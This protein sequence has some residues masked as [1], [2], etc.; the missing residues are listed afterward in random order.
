MKFAAG[1]S[2]PCPGGTPSEKGL[3]IILS[4]RV[5]VTCDTDDGWQ[6]E[7]SLLPG[8]AFGGKE[9]FDG[10]TGMVYTAAEDTMVY[11]IS[12]HSFANLA[13]LKPDVLF[14]VL[15]AAYLPPGKA[16]VP[17]EEHADKDAPSAA[18]SSA[19][20]AS[21]ASGAVAGTAST[22]GSG[23]AAAGAA[24]TSGVAAPAAA[25]AAPVPDIRAQAQA[26]VRAAVVA[27]GDTAAMAQIA[28]AEQAALAA[29][30]D[31]FPKGHKTYPGITKPDYLKLVF[32]K[33]YTCPYCGKAF[34]DYKI[35]GSKLFEDKPVRYDLR[36][37]YRN[38]QTEWYDVVTC[39]NC[40]FSM[41][42]KFFVEPKPIMTAK[43]QD[44]LTTA[45]SAIHMRFDAERDID[46]V[47]TSHY[48]A[49]L[50]AQGYMSVARK[51]QA[52]LWRNLSWLYEDVGDEEMM[53]FAANMTAETYEKVYSETVLT[54]AE[55]QIT[56]IIIAGM[57]YRAG[58][59]RSM[60]RFLFNAKT[61]KEGN[62]EYNKLAADFMEMLGTEGS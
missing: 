28:A 27:A 18:A 9:L 56:C 47:F 25:S 37:F 12:E 23:G 14:E 48:L 24:A 40:L 44:G 38:F 45:R 62:K 29:A 30:G 31:L 36:R 54:K 6:S 2:I 43:F 41:F 11:L 46:Y 51:L 21:A 3:Y 57:Q 15:R 59:D 10:E 13:R 20:S 26:A 39:P 1:K 49:L 32:Q 33:E 50:C 4:G 22:A 52:Q 60:K 19:T 8:E 58:V 35:A 7:G 17:A 34:K 55:E 42:A 5:D 61:A 53:K 16:A